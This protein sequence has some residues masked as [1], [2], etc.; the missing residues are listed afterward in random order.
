MLS[1]REFLR[2]GVGIAG[3]ACVLASEL[4]VGKLYAE[5][6]DGDKTE[7]FVEVDGVRVRRHVFEKAMEITIP[8]YAPKSIVIIGED[9]EKN[10]ELNRNVNGFVLGD[11]YFTAEHVYT[12]AS[13]VGDGRL[14]VNGRVLDLIG[15]DEDRDVAV[16]QLPKELEDHMNDYEFN[17]DVRIYQGQEVIVY[18]SPGYYFFENRKGLFRNGRVIFPN[19]FFNKKDLNG[20]VYFESSV[21]IGDSGSPVLDAM[22]GDVLGTLVKVDE[23]LNIG[24]FTPIRNYAKFIPKN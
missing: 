24:F 18:G 10:E 20:L 4:V 13:R 2:I 9:G 21:R 3:S 15:A 17:P 11:K 8:N 6:F 19:Y 16:F 14:V 5:S 1:R 12:N 22:T 7:E 23:D